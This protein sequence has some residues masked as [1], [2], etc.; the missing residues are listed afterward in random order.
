MAQRDPRWI[1]LTED[2]DHSTVGRHREP[3][4]DDVARATAALQEHGKAGWI[5]VMSQSG[6]ARGVPEVMMV[7]ALGAESAASFDVARERLLARLAEQPT[8]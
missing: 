4:D 7:R 5:A 6:Y 3:D 8:A 1:L 2:G